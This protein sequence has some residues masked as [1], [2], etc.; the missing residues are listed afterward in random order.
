MSKP[1][2]DSAA[3]SPHNTPSGVFIRTF[4]HIFPLSA[5]YAS[6]CPHHVL[7]IIRYLK[8]DLLSLAVEHLTNIIA[9]FP[10]LSTKAAMKFP[11]ILHLPFVLGDYGESPQRQFTYSP[12]TIHR[13]AICTGRLRRIA[14]TTIHY[15]PFTIHRFA[16]CTER[17]R[18]IAPTTIC[19]FLHLLI[20]HSLHLSFLQHTANGI[21][22]NAP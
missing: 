10:R 7:A 18:R 15:S 21:W 8:L 17:L 4:S 5:F 13:F 6:F 9:R 1:T 19:H 16:I 11:T 3:F 2:I 20:C 14:P 12:L 22:H